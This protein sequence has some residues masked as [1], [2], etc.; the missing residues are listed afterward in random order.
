MFACGPQGCAVA[1]G[2]GIGSC[3]LR[4]VLRSPG[5]VGTQNRRSLA[6][7]RFSPVA[8]SVAACI[9]PG[10]VAGHAHAS[11]TELAKP[12]DVLDAAEGVDH[13]NSH[14]LALEPPM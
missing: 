11:A 1:G 12:L 10:R 9:R 8:G 2:F 4:H 14:P 5:W 7:E 13:V 6:C 3:V